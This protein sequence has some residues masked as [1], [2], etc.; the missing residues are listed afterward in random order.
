[1]RTAGRGEEAEAFGEREGCIL[2]GEGDRDGGAGVG[3]KERGGAG[4]EGVKQGGGN[5]GGGGEDE[6][7]EVVGGGVWWGVGGEVGLPAKVCS[8]EGLDGCL[9]VDAVGGRVGEAVGGR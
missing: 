2:E 9:E 4:R 7:V 5:V 1:M 3:G 6:V 8:V